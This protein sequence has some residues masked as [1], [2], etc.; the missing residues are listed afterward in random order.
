MPKATGSFEVTSWDEK[1]YEERPNGGKLTE[2][3]VTQR[4]SGDLSGEGSVV[5]LMCYTEP[6]TAR[7]V[8]LQQVTALQ[9]PGEGSFVMDVDGTFDG[10]VAKGDWSII[11]GSGTGAFHGISGKGHFEAPHG[12]KATF[13]LEYEL[14]RAKVR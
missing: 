4:F 10:A 14:Q 1:T 13:R 12:P 5:W 8:G 6:K 11:T 2:A 9:G 3:K 7:F